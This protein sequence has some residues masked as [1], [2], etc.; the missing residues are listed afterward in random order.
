MVDRDDDLKIG[1]KTSAITLGRFDVAGVMAFYAAYPR[2]LG[3]VWAGSSAAAGRT[4]P[5]IAVAGAACAAWHYTL[6]RE[7]TRDGC[8]RAFRAQSLARLRGLRRR[9]RSTSRCA[10]AAR[11]A[12]GS[13][14]KASRFG[15]NRLA[16]LLLHAG[17]YTNACTKPVSVA[18]RPAVTLSDWRRA[19][20]EGASPGESLHALRRRS[21]AE[22]TTPP[23]SASSRC[24]SSTRSWR[25]LSTAQ[26]IARAT[27]PACTATCRSSACRSRSR[28]TSTSPGCR[29]PRP[30]RRSRTGPRSTRTR[31]APARRGRRDLPRQDQP[32]PVRHRP[33][34]HALARTARPS[35]VFARRPHQRRLEFGL[36]GGGR[37]RRSSRS[38]SAP[39]PPARGACPPASTR[40]SG[41]SRRPARVG[42]S[43]VVPA[44]RS[45][46][47]R[48]GV[49]ADRRRR[50]RGARAD[51]RRRPRRRVQPRSRVGAAAL[52]RCCA[53]ACRTR[54]V[55]GA[56]RS[57]T[58][59]FARRSAACVGAARP[60]GRRRST[61]RRCS[62]S[63]NCSTAARGSPSATPVV[64]DAARTNPERDRPD[65][66][67]A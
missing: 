23:S 17:L 61:S 13:E 50:R 60:P 10:E 36:G 54:R 67:R 53:S 57:A 38:R 34:R 9:R 6:I 20:V 64:A 4:S 55:F 66:A 31:R 8:F 37:A 46:R 5:G 15:A 26:P 43:G 52:P 45:A 7:R 41:S 25:M 62:R 35:S 1:I 49:R 27:A 2:D 28:T 44:C 24:L 42:T 3:C 32:R 56:R 16:R 19:F 47:L 12:V 14:S 39:T 40:S 48:V 21:Q 18:T 63:P 65:G 11:A 58:P 51:R 33:G 59:A 22:A 30:A 29:P